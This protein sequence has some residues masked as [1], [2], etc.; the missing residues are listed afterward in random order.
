L[1]NGTIA[2]EDA[3]DADFLKAISALANDKITNVRIGI[4]RLVLLGV[5]KIF[6][7]TL[8]ILAGS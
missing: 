4:A 8:R 6:I 3:I 7:Q 1:S 2:S 5:G